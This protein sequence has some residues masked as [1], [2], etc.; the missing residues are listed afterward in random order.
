VRSLAAAA[1]TGAAVVWLSP[2][3]AIDDGSEGRAAVRLMTLDPGHFHAAL[4][5]REMY[6]GVAPRVHVYAPLGFD[7]TEHLNRIVRF[8]LRP[9]SPTR[10]EL[11]VHAGPNPLERMLHER[12]GNVVVISGRNRGKIDRIR[13][14]VE[15]GLSVLADKP[16]IISAEDLPALESA[17]DTADRMNVVAYDMMTSRYEITSILQRELLRDEDVFGTIVTGSVSDPAVFM[18]SVHHLVKTVAGTPLLRPAWFFDVAQQGEGIPDVG[19]HLVD[20]VHWMLLPGEPIDYRRDIAVLAAQRWPTVLTR[21][22]FERVTGEKDFPPFLAEQVRDGRLE[23]QCNGSVTYALRGV[24]IRLET[25]WHY[26]APPGTEDRDLAVVR[27]TRA[28]VEV[29]QGR[30]EDYRP[31]LYVVPNLPQAMEPVRAALERKVAALQGAYPGVRVDDLGARLRVRIPDHHRTGHE[32]HFA[33]VARRFLEYVRDPKTLP[34][35]EK[36]NMV[37]KYYVTTMAHVLSNAGH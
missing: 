23:Y 32:T 36:P 14:S 30:E 25:V 33:E 27:G 29:R 17:L 12:P 34:A 31:E 24:H 26:E 16:W 8:N 4:L 6:P 10:W 35:W 19:T 28:S 5:Q 7:L 9:D 13:A 20:R 3:A 21:V 11:E 37:A 15:A 2:A 22:E 18:E 1:I